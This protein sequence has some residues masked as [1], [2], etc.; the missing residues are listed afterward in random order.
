MIRSI[1]SRLRQTSALLLAISLVATAC[2]SSSKVGSSNP[3]S[4]SSNT[5]SGSTV[6]PSGT[7]IVVG[8]IGSYTGPASST[9][10][11]ADKVM[12]AWADS[13]NA[14]GGI[15][16][17]PIKL[18]VKDDGGN[19]ATALADAHELVQQDHVLAIVGAASGPDSAWAPYMQQAKVPV[20][21]GL[22]GS[23]NYTTNTSLFLIGASFLSALW[24]GVHA[25][26]A[27]GG[28]KLGL[29]VCSE[30]PGCKGVAAVVKPTAAQQGLTLAL[31]QEVSA[32]QPD[33]TANCLAA[34]QAGVDAIFL[35]TVVAVWARFATACANQ[36][37]HPHW[38]LDGY[39]PA[40]A[41]VPALNG[42]A[43]PQDAFPGFVNSPTVTS[44]PA[45]AEYLAALKKFAPGVTPDQVGLPGDT[46][47]ASAKLFQAVASK[48]PNNPSPA[49]VFSGLYSLK[50]ET[51][52][53]LAPQP[54]NFP[55]GKPAPPVLC[56]FNVI[57]S[58]GA[59]T[60]PNGLTP[61]CQ[62]AS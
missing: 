51:L 10:A 57:I 56:M 27:M 15:N 29:I 33:Y 20:L 16:G 13:V 59:P 41:Q 61:T 55:A 47:W 4:G 58:N 26:K 37:Y 45:V 62:P 11:G 31:T 44:N 54:L 43:D 52:G 6:A 17:H 9:Y 7:P 8:N 22:T 48:L 12:Q 39:D 46:A 14:S 18:I 53:G 36:N 60:A 42:A 3:T 24:N 38:V 2:G 32:T 35:V 5:T 30:V 28:T 19:P 23:A 21:T 34:K 25:A 50:N 40:M 1:R 49:D